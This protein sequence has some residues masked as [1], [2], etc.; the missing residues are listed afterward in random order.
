MPFLHEPI[1]IHPYTL[2]PR[3]PLSHLIQR[4]EIH[5]ALVRIGNGHGCLQPWPELG[6]LP[7]ERQLGLLRRGGQTSLLDRLRI[8]C[9][10]DSYARAAGRNELARLILPE[11]HAMHPE[12]GPVVKVKC[13]P[14]PAGEAV[15]LRDIPAGRLR[16][17]FNGQ[18]T[19]AQFR[20]FVR[21]LDEPVLR[22]IDFVEDPF[23]APQYIWDEVQRELPFDLAADRQPVSARVDVQKPACDLIRPH[24]RRVVF[25]SYMDHPLGQM[26]AAREA[27]AYYA[28]YPGQRELCGLATH[29]LF[30]P[31]EFIER[32]QMDENRRLKA[33][34]GTGL[35]FDDL[36]QKIDWQPLA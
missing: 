16:L 25:T 2:R 23:S 4:Q 26:F 27:A 30:E 9:K 11:S 36:L 6:D 1:H 31:D 20:D 35:G 21:R 8:C 19:V 12:E 17:D 33:P 3:R 28:V 5:G 10:I 29:T 7:L 18:L 34:E 24:G 32:V 15:R 13:A 22:R 14:D